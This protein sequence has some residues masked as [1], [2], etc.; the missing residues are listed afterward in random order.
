MDCKGVVKGV[1]GEGEGRE[2][3][4]RG[5]GRRWGKGGRARSFLLSFFYD[6]RNAKLFYLHGR[7]LLYAFNVSWTASSVKRLH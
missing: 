6:L 7:R 5:N 4:E 1:G 2:E 3:G